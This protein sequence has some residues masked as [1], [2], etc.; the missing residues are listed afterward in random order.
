MV[1]SLVSGLAGLRVHQQLIDVVGNNLANSNT[2]GYKSS[3]ATFSEILTQLLR[4]GSAP[5]STLGGSN[6]VQIG[7]G[8]RLGTIDMNMSQGSFLSTGRTFDMGLQGNGFFVVN[9]GTQDFYTR[10]GTF[11]LDSNN[12][13][14]DLKNGYKVKDIEGEF[15][16]INTTALF[17]PNPTESLVIKGNLPAQVLGPK[18]AILES[19][20]AFAQ[21]SAATLTGTSTTPF[22]FSA[23]GTEAMT[24]SINGGTAVTITFEDGAFSNVSTATA[25]EV[26]AEINDDL[27]TAG[28]NGQLVATVSAG[29]IVLTTV[30]TG[31]DTSIQVTNGTNNPATTLGLSTS[32]TSGSE[33]TPTTATTLNS[34]PDNTVNYVDGDLITISGTAFD[35]DSFADTFTYG[36]GND[37]TTLGDIVDFINGISGIGATAELDASGNIV[38][39]A[40]DTGETSLSLTI[41]DNTSASTGRTSWSAHTLQVTQTG[42]GPDQ[43]TSTVPVFDSEGNAHN[44][45]LTF[46][47]QETDLRSWDM[48]ATIPEDEGS[49][50]TNADTISNISFTSNGAF[51]GSDEPQITVTFGTG[52]NA[53]SQTI[54]FEFG[55]V[56]SLAGLTHLGNASQ[57]SIQAT[58]DGYSPG[59]LSTISV[60]TDG[61]VQ[62][63]YTNGQLQD[64]GSIGIATFANP[65][66]L[67]RVADTLFAVSTNSGTASISSGL[68]GS[69][70]EVR[71]GVLENSNVEIAE[72]FVKLVEAQRGF[73]ASAKVIQTTD[74]ILGDLNQIV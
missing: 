33:T 70:G 13:L 19:Q 40:D 42:T 17:P 23:A 30:G 25:A 26:A 15:I 49:F 69:A 55:D 43:V 18:P 58:G 59:T 5:T 7:L 21:G 16:N 63:V 31:D 73:Q 72:E 45:T 8:V 12:D 46:T 28:V 61:V 20:T 47:R 37:G 68:T 14:I 27:T 34:L 32:L 41:S 53:T 39:T 22:N 51:N 66:G 4:L 57:A 62:G 29:A 71:S 24:I 3:R 35:G 65:A 36:S 48:V 11:G 1:N 6:P 67:Q 38:L 64:L 52:A 10:A 50:D 44:V 60:R 2:P 74:Q 56:G 54:R 9:N